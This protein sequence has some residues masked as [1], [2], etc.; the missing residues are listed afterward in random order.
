MTARFRFS[1]YWLAD[2]ECVQDAGVEGLFRAYFAEGRDISIS[3]CGNEWGFWSS[4]ERSNEE[5]LANHLVCRGFLELPGKDSNLDEESQNLNTPRRK[6]NPRKQIATSDD[7][8]RS[9]GRSDPSEGGIPDAELTAIVAA[10]PTLPEHI[11]AAIR[12]LIG[13][14]AGLK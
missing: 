5:S 14:I 12:A 11:R 6:P 9:A 4:D 13:T 8:G 1:R 3:R 10:W 2:T 7:A